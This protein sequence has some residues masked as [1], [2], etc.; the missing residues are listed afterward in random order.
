MTNYIPSPSVKSLFSVTTSVSNVNEGSI[1]NFDIAA[2]GYGTGVVYW[3]IT[4]GVNAADFSDTGAF[5]GISGKVVITNNIGRVTKTINADKLTEGAESMQLEIHACE[6]TGTLL[7]SSPTITIN[8]TSIDTMYT[9]VVA[10]GGG[11]GGSG[12]GTAGLYPA[13]AG[14][15]GGGGG[16][17][18][19]APATVINTGETYYVVPGEGGAAG[20]TNTAAISPGTNGA[21]SFILGKTLNITAKGGGGGAGYFATTTTGGQ[22]G[23][24]GGS[25]GGASSPY[26]AASVFT[27]TATTG[28]TGISGQGFAGGATSAIRIN[29]AGGGGASQAG[30][31]STSQP[32]GFGGA[33]ITIPTVVTGISPFAGGSYGGGGS[34]WGSTGYNTITDQNSIQIIT[35]AVGG[36]GLPGTPGDS[37]TGGGGGGG[38]ENT[39]AGN[40]G[41]G[42]VKIAYVSPVGQVFYGGTAVYDPVSKIAQHT[43]LQPDFFSSY[44][45]TRTYTISV[46]YNEIVPDAVSGLIEGNGTITYNISTTNF[47][48]GILAWETLGV[49]ASSFSDG[50]TKGT[51]VITN[52]AGVVSRPTINNTISEIPRT[53]TFALKTTDYLTTLATDSSVLLTDQYTIFPDIY[54]INEL[55]SPTAVTFTITSQAIADNTVVFWTTTGTVAARDFT[56]NTLNGTITIQG[57]SATLV[58]EAYADYVTEGTESFAIQLRSGSSSGTILSVSPVVVINDTATT[59]PT[60]TSFV[61]ALGPSSGGTATPT[62]AG[63]TYDTSGRILINGTGFTDIT[64]VQFKYV[65][66]PGISAA[67]TVVSSTQISAVPPAFTPVNPGY[68]I[69]DPSFYKVI[70]IVSHGS[71]S[72]LTN[73]T[74]AAQ[75]TYQ[76]VPAPVLTYIDPTGGQL[77]EAPVQVFV[78]GNNF[79]S[80]ITSIW[81][82]GGG[83]PLQTVGFTVSAWTEG[84][85][86]PPTRS[87]AGTAT[88]RLYTYGGASNTLTY[89]YAARAPNITATSEVSGGPL[90]GG[91]FTNGAI[92]AFTATGKLQIQGQYFTGV[93]SVKFN[94]VSTPFTFVSST[95]IDA[96]PPAQTGTSQIDANIEII[97]S[98]GTGNSSSNGVYWRYWAKPVITSWNFE[99][100][101]Q[102]TTVNPTTYK[103]GDSLP[104]RA[105]IFGSN[106]LTGLEGSVTLSGGATVSVIKD[107][108]PNAWRGYHRFEPT[109]GAFSTGGAFTITLNTLGGPSNTLSYYVI[110]TPTV[111]SAPT[112]ASITP[113]GSITLQL[114]GGFTDTSQLTTVTVGGVTTTAT[115]NS[116]GVLTI[117]APSI[118]STGWKT[119]S[120]GTIN[121]TV[122]SNVFYVAA[123]TITGFSNTNSVTPGL[124][125][126]P[127][128]GGITGG[129]YI[130]ISSTTL[131][132]GGSY[133]VMSSSLAV[134]GGTTKNGTVG[135][136]WFGDRKASVGAVSSLGVWVTVPAGI[137]AATVPVTVKTG[138]V[139]SGL[140]SNALNWT[141][142]NYLR[143]QTWLIGGGGGGGVGTVTAGGGGGGGGQVL[144]G[145]YNLAVGQGFTVSVGAGGTSSS[146][147]TASSISSQGTANPGLAG[148]GTT[149]GASGGGN[150]GVTASGNGF[151]GGGGGAGGAAVSGGNGGAAY[152][153]PAPYSLSVAAGGGG[154]YTSGSGNNAA[155]NTG[156]GGQGSLITATIAGSDTGSSYVASLYFQN[157]GGTPFKYTINPG[158]TSADFHPTGSAYVRADLINGTAGSGSPW[159]DT[160]SYYKWTH[161]G[162]GY[163][164]FGRGSASTDIT[165][166]DKI[167]GVASVNINSLTPYVGAVGEW[168]GG[169]YLNGSFSYNSW[170]RN[171]T[172]TVNAQG[173]ANLGGLVVDFGIGTQTVTCVYIG[174]G[175][176]TTTNTTNTNYTT[177]YLR[178][179]AYTSNG[180]SSNPD[181]IVEL[182]WDNSN[183][184]V[185]VSP[186]YVYTP[187]AL[188]SLAFIKNGRGSPTYQTYPGGAGGSGR[189]I[190]SYLAQAGIS[191]SLISNASSSSLTGS[192]GISGSNGLIHI[193]QFTNS[194]SAQVAAITAPI[195]SNNR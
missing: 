69:V 15:G 164:A 107:Y 94:G 54:T 129:E 117:T 22:N 50:L 97:T 150:S 57:N 122:T 180:S 10:G 128:G 36:G 83:T 40:G 56:D 41:S 186:A 67:F 8:D 47:G 151:G 99:T 25:G 171:T 37:R 133:N 127:T 68:P 167:N 139:F 79:N 42:V 26:N 82:F 21:D 195:V 2:T 106:I 145:S 85:L 4:G 136:I 3:I 192:S 170:Y 168:K 135:E 75:I 131:L 45:G 72:N 63:A 113:P 130:F 108:D 123:P 105:Q 176:V 114:G 165:P 175:R 87:T 169:V 76:Y 102:P 148:S 59:P 20:Q 13:G 96:T 5:A 187:S 23:L 181:I 39:P 52:D 157:Y 137:A 173:S 89:T 153:I 70:V 121:G 18:L 147:G 115:L 64:D 163:S 51:V 31:G 143:T 138:S 48:N 152:S 32:Y 33:G 188:L 124:A 62:A 149:G 182:K 189:I 92:G 140:T 49:L 58:R 112:N 98:Q 154:G 17:V 111:A 61:P 7:A 9:L 110:G 14:G 132:Q 184:V 78:K 109:S 74:V 104:T 159:N 38:G 35:G 144:L 146:N 120:I 90:T 100:S 162:S 179:E 71:I 158:L 34:G 6:P 86:N 84:T 174:W 185:Q 155:A 53:I 194:T 118:S 1:I 126:S 65:D 60:V 77:L 161:Y 11:G 166:A 183:N 16:G 73:S 88:I 46:T 156:S 177:F 55:G 43:F 12:A 19:Y 28:G 93:T 103:V 29:A 125:T 44:S 134:P 141:Y 142:G 191:T 95:R 190:I 24:T 193:Y 27:G 91:I 81:D 178:Y 66:S 160:T 119:I 80:I 101:G 116:A 172:F 30:I